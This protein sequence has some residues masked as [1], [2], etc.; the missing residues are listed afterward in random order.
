[1]SKAKMDLN[2]MINE[3]DKLLEKKVQTSKKLDSEFGELNYKIEKKRI[4]SLKCTNC[5]KKLPI[6]K[7]DIEE[8]MNE[9]MTIKEYVCTNCDMRNR[10]KIKFDGSPREVQADIQQFEKGFKFRTR[11]AREL[12]KKELIN[13]LSYEERLIID[14]RSRFTPQEQFIIRYLYLLYTENGLIKDGET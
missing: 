4:M 11:P 14:G 9:G 10:I 8:F 12:T 3:R 13:R 7:E 5:N 2:K 6:E 1:M